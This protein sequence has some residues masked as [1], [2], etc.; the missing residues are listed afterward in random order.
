[1]RCEWTIGKF[2]V[3]Q[4]PMVFAIDS[5]LVDNLRWKPCTALEILE[6]IHIYAIR[7][8][9]NRLSCTH[10]LFCFKYE[11][12]AFWAESKWDFSIKWLNAIFCKFARWICIYCMMFWIWCENVH[13][14]KLKGALY[15]HIFYDWI[16][17]CQMLSNYYALFFHAHQFKKTLTLMAIEAQCFNCIEIAH[18]CSIDKSN[19]LMIAEYEFDNNRHG[20]CGFYPV[21]CIDMRSPGKWYFTCFLRWQSHKCQSHNITKHKTSKPKTQNTTVQ[22]NNKLNYRLNILTLKMIRINLFAFVRTEYTVYVLSHMQ[23]GNA[24]DE[25]HFVPALPKSDFHWNIFREISLG[26]TE[27]LH[28]SPIMNSV[29]WNMKWIF[30]IS[31]FEQEFNNCDSSVMVT[32]CSTWTKWIWILHLIQHTTLNENLRRNAYVLCENIAIN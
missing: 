9:V 30:C 5:E 18:N 10:Y 14:L 31:Y 2:L 28:N 21:K 4:M 19:W 32:K 26:A 25:I 23:C 27:P 15:I 6:Y 1:M 24:D 22:F 11:W 29:S 17:V 12:Q 8:A 13:I 3:N 7:P 20:F 16:F